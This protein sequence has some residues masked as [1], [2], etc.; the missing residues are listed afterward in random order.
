[1]YLLIG[2]KALINKGELRIKVGLYPV[3]GNM[4]ANVLMMDV[5]HFVICE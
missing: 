3:L 2:S 4:H 1:M 5:F